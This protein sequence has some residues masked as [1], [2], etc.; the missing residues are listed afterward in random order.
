MQA[1][2]TAA[3]AAKDRLAALE[4]GRKVGEQ[5]HKDLVAVGAALAALRDRDGV[6]EKQI[7]DGEAERRE[8]TRELQHLRER[9]AKLEGLQEAKPAV[10]PAVAEE[11]KPDGGQ[12]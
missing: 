6:L 7:K 12:P 5:D 1:A 9:L 8:L 2:L 11:K 4:D 10:K 3:A